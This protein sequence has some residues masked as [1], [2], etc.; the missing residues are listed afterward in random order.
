MLRSFRIG[1]ATNSSSAH[2][3]ILH[4]DPKY[5]NMLQSD[6]VDNISSYGRD[7]FSFVDPLE[8]LSYLI[9]LHGRQNNSASAHESMKLAATLPKI[10]NQIGEMS[11]ADIQARV[12]HLE[13][14]SEMYEAACP[15]GITPNLWFDF[16]INAPV[17]LHGYDDNNDTYFESVNRKDPGHVEIRNMKYKQDGNAL[18]GYN[19]QT[20]EK[21]RWSPD[22]YEKSTY[23]ELVDLKITDYCGWG[24]KFCYQ[25]STTKGQ[26]APIERLKDIFKTLSDKKVFEVA[27]GGGEPVE[28]PQFDELFILAKEYGITLNFT[29]YGV[30]WAKDPN[31]PVIV[32]MNK[33][34]WAGGIGVSVHT[35]K[36]IEKVAKLQ[37]Y[38]TENKVYQGKVMAQ[39]VIGATPMNA[40]AAIL[41]ECISLDK[42]LLLLGYKTTGRGAS[43]KKKAD[44]KKAVLDILNRAKS[45]VDSPLETSQWGYEKDRYFTLS[46]DTAFLDIYKD[47]LDEV[48]IPTVLRTSPEGKFSM[49][50]DGVENTVAPSSY[51][52]TQSITPWDPNTFKETFAKF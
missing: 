11:L 44:D 49:Y 25:A 29:T 52:D 7:Q 16:I 31:H 38:L 9:W 51:C 4:S 8:K 45:H 1:F 23:P 40:T 46:V 34:R 13:F 50:I 6:T 37:S 12:E 3:I 33:T 15:A 43:F 17:A 41:E 20:G 35:K 27:I 30:E 10:V 2:S 26:H 39:S 42:P 19:A 24:C 22:L 47:I 21:F 32:A 36:D 48:A 18:I 5:L 28:H 14:E